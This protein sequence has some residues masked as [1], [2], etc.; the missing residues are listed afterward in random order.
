MPGTDDPLLSIDDWPVSV[1]AAGWLDRSGTTGRRGPTSR[2]F[3]LASVTKP[4]FA[5][6]VL[7]AIE[8]GS[9][10]LET[11]ASLPGVTVRHLLAHAGGVDPDRRTLLAA[12]GTRRIYS[13]AGFEMLADLLSDA[14]GFAP[15]DYLREAVFAPLAMDN[16]VLMGSPA[17][18]AVSTVDDLLRFGAELLAPT[19]VDPSTLAA[20]T[21]PVFELLGGVLPGFGRQEPNW[22]GL[23]FEIRGHKSPHWTA[24]SNSPST[25]G[26]FGRAGTMLWVDPSVGRAA[27]AL[28]EREFG[29]W[30][31]T[32]W[33]ALSEAILRVQ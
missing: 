20:A 18:G 5:H 14:T 26:H 33:P 2:P 27:V 29:P 15:A 11:E 9:L 25:F 24:S 28:T 3:P 4:L 21:T 32:G 23:G 16:S 7:V 22:W 12:P 8:E 17:H 31:A 19:L 1:A 30:A 10:A 6:A 13:N